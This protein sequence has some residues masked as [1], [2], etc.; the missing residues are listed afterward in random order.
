MFPLIRSLAAVITALLLVVS[1]AVAHDGVDALTNDF[2]AQNGLH[3]L[4]TSPILTQFAEQ[5]AR[6]IVSDFSHDFGWWDASGCRGVG[7]NIHYRIPAASDPASYSVQ[8]WI[9]SPGHRANMLGDWDVQGSA[10]YLA[11]NGGHYAVQLFGFDCGT[12]S[13]PS[14]TPQP[15]PQPTPAPTHTP[16]PSEAPVLLLPDTSLSS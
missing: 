15:T 4:Q 12:T 13:Q 8:A 7:E 16:Q 11:P 10:I 3:S 6:E 1:T 2:R 5:R 9:N 14:P